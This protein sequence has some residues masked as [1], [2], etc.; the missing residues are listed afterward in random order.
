MGTHPTWGFK[1]DWVIYFTVLTGLFNGAFTK[2]EP[3]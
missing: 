3:K 1:V 2:I